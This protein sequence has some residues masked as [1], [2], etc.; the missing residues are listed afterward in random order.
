MLRRCSSVL[1]QSA[2]KCQL[3]V[4]HKRSNPGWAY[5]DIEEYVESKDAFDHLI[6]K[7]DVFLPK[8]KSV[9]YAAKI[10]GLKVPVCTK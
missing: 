9:E 6:E 7:Y 4:F 10:V 3:G 2:S 1:S 8:E 5:S